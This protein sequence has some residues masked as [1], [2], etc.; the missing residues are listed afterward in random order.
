MLKKK[1]VLKN[2]SKFFSSLSIILIL[3]FTMV[4]M[5]VASGFEE[6]RYKTITIKP[7]DTLWSIA[8]KNAGNIDIR[9]YIYNVKK[10][11][12]MDSGKIYENTSIIIPE[13]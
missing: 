8:E 5:A 1:Y 4:Y 2:K 13:N 7:G 6:S 9:E 10:I 3:V 12:N 11:N